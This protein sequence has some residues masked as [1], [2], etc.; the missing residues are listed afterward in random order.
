MLDLRFPRSP[1]QSRR[2]FRRRCARHLLPRARPSARSSAGAQR[3]RARALGRGR[4]PRLS[5]PRFRADEPAA[6]QPRGRRADRD[7]RARGRCAPP[8]GKARRARAG[9]NSLPMRA[10]SNAQADGHPGAA[11]AGRGAAGGDGSDRLRADARARRAGRNGLRKARRPA[12]A[13]ASTMPSSAA[14]SNRASTCRCRATPT[15]RTCAA[16]AARSSSRCRT[17]CRSAASG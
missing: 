8:R 6:A 4:D 1:L 11:F 15:P 5:R 13:S 7:R 2:H 9:A 12:I 16:R 3:D 10:L 14:A 17:R